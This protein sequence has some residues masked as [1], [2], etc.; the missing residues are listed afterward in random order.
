M[1]VWKLDMKIGKDIYSIFFIISFDHD[2]SIFLMLISLFDSPI[3]INLII[4]I[5]P[6]DRTRNVENMLQLL[7]G[8]SIQH[9]FSTLPDSFFIEYFLNFRSR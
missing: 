6:V 3:L 2:T 5:V 8:Q 4:A 9:A 1:I 7:S